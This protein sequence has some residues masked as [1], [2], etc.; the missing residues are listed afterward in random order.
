MRERLARDQRGS[1]FVEYAIVL[2]LLA[3]GA[4]L[5]LIGVGIQLLL[6]FRCQQALL[7]MPMP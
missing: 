4:S 3:L 5:A 6:L 2:V 7:L 1:V